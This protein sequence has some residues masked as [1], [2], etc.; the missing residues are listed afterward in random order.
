[1]WAIVRGI[2]YDG[3]DESDGAGG[4]LEA[5]KLDA[6]TA[7]I[8]LRRNWNRL[9]ETAEIRREAAGRVLEH[10]LGCLPPESRGSN[11]LAETTLGDLLQ[12]VNSD[13]VLRS[14]VQA[15]HKLLDRA[16]LWLHEQDAIRLNKGLAVFRPAMTIRL[17]QRDRRRGFSNVDFQPLALHYKG[18]VL[19]IHVMKE[20]AERG[21]AAMSDSLQLAMDYFSMQEKDFLARW[22]PGRDAEIGRAT[23]PESWRVIVE[24]LKNPVQQRIVAD[25]R[26]QT[27]VLVLA[28]PGSG[29]TRVLVHHIAYLIRVLR[30]KARGILALVYNRHAAVEIR[31]RLGDLIGDDARGVTVLTCHALAMRL[32]GASFTGRAERP[33]EEM[34]RNVLRS[35]IEILRGNDLLPEEADARRERLLA[36]FRWILV[37]EYQDIG[38]EEYD[39]ISALAGRTLDEDHGKLSL[40]AVGD[41]DQNIY[42]FNGASVEYIRRFEADYGPKPAFLTENYRSTRNIIEAANALIEPSRER[43][44]A[45]RPIQIDRSRAAD[46]RGGE[47]ERLDPVSRGRVQ[48][49]PPQRD[50]LRQAQ[51]VMLELQRLAEL[52]RDWDWARCAIIAREWEYLVP[53]RA[54][55]ELNEIPVQM[56][57]ENMP[58]FWRLRETA[59]LVNW[60]RQ[61]DP[62]IVDSAALRERLDNSASGPW[63]DLLRQAIEEHSLEIG[64]GETPVGHF[65]EWLAEWG[66][67]VRRRQKGLL[68]LTAHR[69]KG[70]EFDHVAVLD[71]GW[72]R[73]GRDEDADAPRRLYYVAMTRAK[74]TL[75]LA[76]MDGPQRLH[77]ALRQNPAVLRREKF[78]LPP[79]T[80]ELEYCHVQPELKD[81]DLGYA[82]RRKARHP[83]QRAIAGLSP[84]DRLIARPSNSGRWELQ[85]S[86]GTTVGRLS[87]GFQPPRGMSPRSADVFAIVAWSREAS[88]PKYRDS[89]KSDSWEVVV[90]ELVF[91]RDT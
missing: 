24:S 46:P 89:I 50:S 83:I 15:P 40:F 45:N 84:G 82:G 11:L 1:M 31:R 25:S 63:C 30:E 7:R 58:S 86:S 88:D 32:A 6:E 57:N 10:L 9:E 41:D 78:E 66:R 87:K 90:P 17:D 67:E 59:Q 14:R 43:M 77:D 91:E 70:L 65:I 72:N 80:A 54:Y 79:P 35:A 52:S 64:E 4:S 2:S 29:K 76:R 16:L 12:A 44:K 23:T 71:G 68:L 56:G 48:I 47:W 42:A 62:R 13:I 51:S 34:F 53:V 73:V 49:L 37:D 22:L 81:V 26:K 85:N 69:A 28:G 36:G 19:Q 60:L 75:A 74:K 8:T 33:D 61:R 5:R 38:P 39:L 18:Q 21:L 20:Y 3:R 55:C 27:N